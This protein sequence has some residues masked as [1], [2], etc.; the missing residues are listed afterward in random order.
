MRGQAPP[1]PLGSEPLTFHFDPFQRSPEGSK[2][3]RGSGHILLARKMDPLLILANLGSHKIGFH[4]FRNYLLYLFCE[5]RGGVK[6]VNFFTENQSCSFS[7]S[8]QDAPTLR[9]W[10]YLFDDFVNI[11]IFMILGVA[12]TTTHTHTP[13]YP[14]PPSPSRPGKKTRREAGIL[15]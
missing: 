10:G 2:A 15:T 14:P 5:K 11:T 12:S 3:S 1:A 4:I 9:T 6:K 13:G 8:V 7:I